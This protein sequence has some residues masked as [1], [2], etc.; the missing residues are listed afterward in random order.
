MILFPAFPGRRLCFLQPLLCECP[1]YG[2]DHWG[3]AKLNR[4]LKTGPGVKT[5]SA[6]LRA[7]RGSV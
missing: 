6:F 1:S 3:V 4:G 5:G 7:G 2:R